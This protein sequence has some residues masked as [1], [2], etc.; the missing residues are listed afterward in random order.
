MVD[1][2]PTYYICIHCYSFLFPRNVWKHISSYRILYYTKSWVH[3][4]YYFVREVWTEMMMAKSTDF[5]MLTPQCICSSGRL[6]ALFQMH[7]H[8]ILFMLD[9]LIMHESKVGKS[10]YYLTARIQVFKSTCRCQHMHRSSELH[11]K[12]ILRHMQLR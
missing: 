1:I 4:D 10:E 11:I 2:F 6:I 7:T 5:Y 12:D 8:N 9:I 3:W